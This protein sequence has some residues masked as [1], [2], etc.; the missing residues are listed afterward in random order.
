M[1]YGQDADED[2]TGYAQ[3]ETESGT[4][5]DDDDSETS[6]SSNETSEHVDTEERVEVV[7]NK[8]V[9][10]DVWA[11]VKKVQQ[12]M[13]SVLRAKKTMFQSLVKT[14]QMRLHKLTGLSG[15]QDQFNVST[16]T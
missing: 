6:E 14:T 2:D 15:L 3:S 13:T 7:G 9:T 5:S 1:N 4:E 10:F 12:L 8:Q 16:L 11:Q